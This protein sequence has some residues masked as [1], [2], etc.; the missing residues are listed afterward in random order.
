[1]FSTGLIL[2]GLFSALRPC[3]TAILFL[4][5]DSTHFFLW[6]TASK[7]APTH[8]HPKSSLLRLHQG[9]CCSPPIALGSRR[10]RCQHHPRNPTCCHRTNHPCRPLFLPHL[11]WDCQIPPNYLLAP[12]MSLR[13]TTM[14]ARAWVPPW[15]T[16]SELKHASSTIPTRTSNSWRSSPVIDPLQTM[17]GFTHVLYITLTH[18]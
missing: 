11:L 8:S 1:V 14:N 17:L 15:T 10:R 7:L 4:S 12:S 3:F 18:H 6:D 16:F 13:L 5:K 9:P 2:P